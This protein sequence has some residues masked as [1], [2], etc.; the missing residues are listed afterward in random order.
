MHEAG[1]FINK[2][3]IKVKLV[4]SQSENRPNTSPPSLPSSPHQQGFQEDHLDAVL[5]DRHMEGK[6]P[7]I[8]LHH[9]NWL[10]GQR[11]LHVS[12]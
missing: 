1:Y 8:H 3:L 11:R 5:Y 2:I 6:L 9:I 7:I 10:C 4:L 12:T